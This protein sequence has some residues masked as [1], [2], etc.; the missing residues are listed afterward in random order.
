VSDGG[1]PENPFLFPEEN[2]SQYQHFVSVEEK[3]GGQILSTLSSTEDVELEV[4]RKTSSF[5]STH[6]TL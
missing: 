4:L 3:S 2:I 6:L 5:F 1:V